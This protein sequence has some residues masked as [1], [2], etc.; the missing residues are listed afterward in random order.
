ME[1]DYEISADDYAAA[2]ILYH[3]LSRKLRVGRG[4]IFAGA[5]L[6]VVTLLERDRGLSPI[7]L[8]AIGVWWIWAGIGSLFPGMFQRSYRK[9]YRQLYLAGE[10]YHACVDQDGFQVVG[11]NRTWNNP[12]TEVSPKGEDD[13][14]FMLHSRGTLF[15]FAK[16][17]LAEEQQRTLRDLAGLPS[18]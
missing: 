17:Y 3:K 4:W 14:V 5:V 2:A 18:V 16:R 10:K 12:W 15:I 7:L 13:H 11:R 1:F 8:G 6:L 9:Y